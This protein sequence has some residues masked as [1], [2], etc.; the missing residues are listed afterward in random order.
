MT[1]N[2]P[3]PV[4]RSEVDASRLLLSKTPKHAQLILMLEVR[5]LEQPHVSLGNFSADAPPKGFFVEVLP[6]DPELV[7]TQLTC[8]GAMYNEREYVLHIANYGDRTVSV[9]VFVMER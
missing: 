2:K 1:D 3:V 8:L 9:E 4:P 5:P 6:S 7:V